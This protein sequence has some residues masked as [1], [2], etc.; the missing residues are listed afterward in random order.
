MNWNAKKSKRRNMN[1]SDILAATR[2]QAAESAWARASLASNLRHAL[3]DAGDFRNATAL[4]RI[5]G[6]ALARAASLLPREVRVGI[7][8]ERQI[9]LVIA[10]GEAESRRRTPQDGASAA[11]GPPNPGRWQ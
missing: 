8:S 9:G 6:Q 2:E 7:D 3:M 1:F 4:G 10:L 11:P 5:K